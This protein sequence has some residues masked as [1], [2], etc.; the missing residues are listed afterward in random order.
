MRDPYHDNKIYHMAHKISPTG[1]VSA[2]CFTKPRAIDLTRAL[3]TVREHAVTCPKCK[4]ALSAV[5]S[6]ASPRE[7]KS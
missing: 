7:E 2:L 6:S 3:W 4:A 1:A 5:S